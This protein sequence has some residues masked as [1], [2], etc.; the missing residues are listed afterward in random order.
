LVPASPSFWSMCSASV[1]LPRN[2]LTQATWLSGTLPPGYPRGLYCLPDIEFHLFARLV[3]R[4]LSGRTVPVFI[5]HKTTRAQPSGNP[6]SVRGC[7]YAHLQEHSL[8][9]GQQ[10]SW[11]WCTT[12]CACVIWFARHYCVPII[13]LASSAEM[14]GKVGIPI[15]V[16]RSIIFF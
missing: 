9:A 11:C 16:K 12:D 5:T 6:R 7:A 3:T 2:V 1:H 13:F 14:N 4:S 8:L 10:V 15:F